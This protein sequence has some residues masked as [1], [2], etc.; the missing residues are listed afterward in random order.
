MLA[1]HVTLHVQQRQ[2]LPAAR[3]MRSTL[4]QLLLDLSPAASSTPPPALALLVFML[5][6]LGFRVEGLGFRV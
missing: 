5:T 1:R 6:G 2:W 4:S 3:I